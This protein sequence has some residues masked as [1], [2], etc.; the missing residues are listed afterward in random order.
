MFK[1]NAARSGIHFAVAVF[2]FSSLGVSG[3][4]GAAVVGQWN[5]NASTY[6]W[7]TSSNFSSLYTSAFVT[8]GN[9]IDPSGTDGSV[10]L[11]NLN[12]YTH[13]VMNTSA[14]A[15]TPAF[16]DLSTWVHGGGVLILFANGTADATSNALGNAILS[17]VGSSITLTG[18][19]VGSGSF[20]TVGSLTGTDIAVSGITNNPLT[21]FRSN[22]VGGG[23]LLALNGVPN[24]QN[25]LGAALRVDSVGLGKVY[26]FGEHFES[27]SRISGGSGNANLQLFLNLLAQG[28]LQGGGGP[29]GPGSDVPEPGTV[30]L[31]AFA[32][33]GVAWLKHKR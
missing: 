3:L 7:A 6:N 13:F 18:S 2:A 12:Q 28:Q 33:A 14:T 5:Q 8:G 10:V 17:G 1:S 26:V 31:T 9:S 16:G 11:S 19:T 22:T 32:L 23:T 4:Q 15:S 20:S 30:F 25:N 21:M 24:P 29:T 27:N